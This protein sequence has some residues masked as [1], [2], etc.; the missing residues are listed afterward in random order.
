VRVA[1]IGDGLIEI[2]DAE[3]PRELDRESPA[4]SGHSDH[5]SRPAVSALRIRAPAFQCASSVAEAFLLW[6]T[7]RMRDN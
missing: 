5:G 1:S 2:W 3:L 7:S 6:R 4:R